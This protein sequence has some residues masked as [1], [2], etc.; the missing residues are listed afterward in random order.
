MVLVS[1][2]KDAAGSGQLGTLSMGVQYSYNFKI[3]DAVSFRPGLHFSYL[4][5]GLH[6][7]NWS[8]SMRSCWQETELYSL[9][10]LK[11]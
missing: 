11:R 5:H 2:Y 1:G 8:L 9:S 6:G 3:F 7:I 10:R 4:E